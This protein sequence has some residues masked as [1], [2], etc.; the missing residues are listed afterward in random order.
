MD[1]F[2]ASAQKYARAYLTY[3]DDESPTNKVEREKLIAEVE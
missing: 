3:G 1:S 2:A